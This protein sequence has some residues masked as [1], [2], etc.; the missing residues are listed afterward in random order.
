MEVTPLNVD[1]VSGSVIWDEAG[2]DQ[3][4]AWTISHI[5]GRGDFAIVYQAERD[6]QQA[7]IKLTSRGGSP[8]RRAQIERDALKQLRHPA[9]PTVLDEGTWHDSDF[10]AMSLVRGE[11]L[12]ARVARKLVDGELHG[13]IATL[14]ILSRLLDALAHVHARDLVHRDIKDANLVYDE[15]TGKVGL[16][17]FGFCQK[18]G[19]AGIRTADSFWRVGAARFSP[20]A[21]LYDSSLSNP[22]HDV[23]AMGVIGYLLLTGEH[24]WSVSEKEGLAALRQRH[25]DRPLVSVI[26]RNSFVAPELSGFISHLLAR[27]DDQ[28]PSAAK[29]AQKAQEILDELTARRLAGGRIA[30]GGPWE[31]RSHVLRDPVHGDIRLSEHEYQILNTKE[32][33]RLRWIRQLGLTNLVFH[34]AE[35]SRLSHAIGCV[36]VV[37]KMLSTMED[38]VGVRI[39]SE[40]RAVA[41]LFALVHDVPHIAFGH[42]LEDE[43]GIWTRHD[44]NVSRFERLLLA[45]TSQLGERLRA[46][47]VGR[48]VLDL[49]D[50]EQQDKPHKIKEL[51]LGATGADVLDYVDRD[52]EFCGINHRIDTAIYR[53]FRIESF[54]KLEDQ[55]LVSDI[56]GKYGVRVDRELAVETVLQQRYTMFLKVYSHPAK[57]ASS[58]LLARAVYDASQQEHPLEEAFVEWFGDEGLLRQLRGFPRETQAHKCASLIL[59]RRIP[60]GVYRANLLSPGARTSL[61]YGNMLG[62]VR[63]NRYAT[64]EGRLRLEKEIGQRADFDP[65]RI[66]VY[67]PAKAP[68]YQTI[69]HWVMQRRNRPEPWAYEGGITASHLDLWQFWTFVRGGT[70]Q[71]R[72]RVAMVSQEIVKRPN[73]IDNYRPDAS[74]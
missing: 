44:A 67:C 65:E 26:D 30:R 9:I 21:K 64:P 23:F 74:V 36:F 24:P 59:Q 62:W 2:G 54:L 42:T 17:D 55:H 46:D 32:M 69:E 20:L 43:F 71:E 14:R 18:S 56:A 52:A 68:G 3:A 53:Q 34:G 13:D 38:A 31:S 29:A 73:T 63:D 72:R 61:A 39:D 66:F 70:A 15:T 33:Q 60:E 8:E 28:R 45:S 6:G 12:Q 49:M 7:A 37:E 35:H 48:A 1:L 40:L 47:A 10:F 19:V 50:P 5:L 22:A 4:S 27:H 57:L 16:L 51:V 11:T 58:C 41:R 25:E